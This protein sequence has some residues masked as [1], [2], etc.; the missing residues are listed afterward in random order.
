MDTTNKNNLLAN[1]SNQFNINVNGTNKSIRG[2]ALNVPFVELKKIIDRNIGTYHVGNL[3]I[4]KIATFGTNIYLDDDRTINLSNEEDEV[5]MKIIRGNIR[6]LARKIVEESD[7]EGLLVF[8]TF[9]IAKGVI[10]GY[11]LEEIYKISDLD[12][13]RKCFE[14]EVNIIK[15]AVN[16]NIFNTPKLHLLNDSN[17]FSRVPYEEIFEEDNNKKQVSVISSPTNF[18][19]DSLFSTPTAP[20]RTENFINTNSGKRRSLDPC[21]LPFK[22]SLPSP[23]ILN[24]T[25]NQNATSLNVNDVI[26]AIELGLSS[27][28]SN[29]IEL[30]AVRNFL[31]V[32]HIELSRHLMQL[33]NQYEITENMTKIKRK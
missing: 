29:E 5:S 13:F 7:Y 20:K 33:L 11:V 17:G 15:A 16:A 19:C 32:T 26:N 25:V 22:R 4:M 10:N 3:K 31:G 27:E 6:T 1:V 28:R 23:L 24:N 21:N 9:N 30:Q 2:T 8:A 18:T 14:R 12:S